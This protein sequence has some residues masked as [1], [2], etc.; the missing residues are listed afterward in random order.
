MVENSLAL[1]RRRPGRLLALVLAVLSAAA[2][3]VQVFLAGLNV[4]LAPRWWSAHIAF[5]HS[6]GPLLIALAVTI[7][8]AGLPARARWLSLAMVLLFG[9]QYN[10]RGLAS[11]LQAPYLIPLHAVNALAL[12]WIAVTLATWTWQAAGEPKGADH[13]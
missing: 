3:V 13:D 10:V 7:W 1:R 12:F 8:L 9:L 4:F 5:G 6:I 2:I 11:L